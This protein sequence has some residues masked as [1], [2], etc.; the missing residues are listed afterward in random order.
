MLAVVS[1][2][3][4]FDRWPGA[5]VQSPAQTLVLSDGAPAIR[6]SA[7]S[8]APS[9]TPAPR[10]ALAPRVTTAPRLTSNG[11]GVAGEQFGGG[12]RTPSTTPGG[13]APAA[14]D[15]TKAL[16][17]VQDTTTPIFDSI[18]NPSSTT[19]QIAD[20]A[21]AVTDTAGRS[22]T[23]V[24]PDAGSAVTV[25]GQTAADAL[26]GAPLPARVIPGH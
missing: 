5:S 16:Q 10:G 20:G 11:G 8:T 7:N 23:D 2:V 17:P 21:Q 1:A 3:V 13:S 6:V 18:S 19:S 12:V 15:P 24:S 4:A 9:A 26:R 14:P 22:L 25:A